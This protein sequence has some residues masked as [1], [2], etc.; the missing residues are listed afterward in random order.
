MINSIKS[1]LSIKYL[2]LLALLSLSICIVNSTN[3]VYAILADNHYITLIPNVLFLL[4]ELR[5]FYTLKNIEE[6]IYIRS[7]QMKLLLISIQMSIIYAMFYVLFQ[8]FVVFYIIGGIQI[9]SSAILLTFLLTNL[10][11]ILL[12]EICMNLLFVGMSYSLI[13]VV[14]FS[15]NFGFHYLFVTN[16]LSILYTN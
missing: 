7:A 8:Y 9:G 11:I 5:R 3:E 2:C 6:L 12:E 1:L 16:F 10:L 14:I 4:F 15:M 13:V